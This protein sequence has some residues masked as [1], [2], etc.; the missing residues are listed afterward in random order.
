[1]T[2]LLKAYQA[3]KDL[4]THC[5]NALRSA[6]EW[7][8]FWRDA[9]LVIGVAVGLWFGIHWYKERDAMNAA[10]KAHDR[11][12]DSTITENAAL[13]TAFDSVTAQVAKLNAHMAVLDAGNRRD[14]VAIMEI[15]KALA[16]NTK[17]AIF[18]LWEGWK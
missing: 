13:H 4:F 11:A 5:K 8:W 15:R 7:V 1:M 9:G 16:G 6:H 14:T 10:I 18:K 17:A 2:H 12:R 3:A